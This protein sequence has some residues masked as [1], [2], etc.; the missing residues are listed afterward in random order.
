MF[1]KA[2]QTQEE[3]WTFDDGSTL[4]DLKTL[5]V[6][7]LVKTMFGALKKAISE[8]EKLKKRCSSLE[9]QIAL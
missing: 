5:D 1:P 9:A 6:D 7:Q 3:E 8:I 4:S 2:V